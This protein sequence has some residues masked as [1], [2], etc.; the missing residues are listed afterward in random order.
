MHTWPQA[1]TESCGLRAAVSPRLTVRSTSRRAAM[2]MSALAAELQG[3]ESVTD[4]EES[5]KRVGAAVVTVGESPPRKATRTECP[6]PEPEVHAESAAD[7]EPVVGGTCLA[8]GVG[9]GTVASPLS[10]KV[11]VQE[12]P[13]LPVLAEEVSPLPADGVQEVSAAAA[14]A[15]SEDASD[16][17]HGL[18]VDALGEELESLVGRGVLADG[19]ASM[20]SENSER[21]LVTGSRSETAPVNDPLKSLPV[22]GSAQVS[23]AGS[24]PG[25]AVAMQPAVLP[26]AMSKSEFAGAVTLQAKVVAAREA[27][28]LGPMVSSGQDLLGGAGPGMVQSVAALQAAMQ[29]A[30]RME[31]FSAA[32]VCQKEIMAAQA[33]AAA[34]SMSEDPSSASASIPALE[35][36]LREAVE[37][38]DYQTA[39][40]VQVKLF[41]A[42]QVASS[43]APSA[44]PVACSASARRIPLQSQAAAVSV[45]M[46][47]ALL[48]G[49]MANVR[50]GQLGVDE[51]SR[52][53]PTQT[54]HRAA[55]LAHSHEAVALPAQDGVCGP[56]LQQGE[57]AKAS[58]VQLRVGDSTRPQATSTSQ[59]P[60][61]LAQSG[62]A[63]ALSGQEHIPAMEAELQRA[64]D[65]CDFMRAE[66]VQA[67]IEKARSA[68]AVSRE[69][70][71]LP[72]QDRIVA[73]EAELKEVIAKRDFVRAQ[74]VQA[75]IGEAR[76]ADASSRAL[77]AEE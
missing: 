2:P 39:G 4:T 11:P 38:A 43:R 50:S 24:V 8:G 13:S 15:A 77:Q 51:S 30:I 69:V 73:L 40:V 37:K 44:T 9:E 23:A 18:T 29:E 16:V 36:A 62:E 28:C 3:D 53:Q 55:G 7:V 1:V 34:R 47:P 32:A 56:A 76:A 61:G 12:V 75:Q 33:A 22:V 54:M 57:V 26:Q 58:S 66:A 41:A 5:I 72:A 67:Q 6:E 20:A 49:E 46:A 31:D 52:P 74:A 65:K 35:A 21:A 27:Q 25:A 42:R 59:R 48:Q 14:S 45:G 19:A 60:A 64:V 71:V 70:P 17:A 10:E 68:D 63:A